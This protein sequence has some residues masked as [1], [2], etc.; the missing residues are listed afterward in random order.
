MSG[1]GAVVGGAVLAGH[2]LSEHPEKYPTLRGR[3]A[4]AMENRK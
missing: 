2:E 4:E 3:I 1:L